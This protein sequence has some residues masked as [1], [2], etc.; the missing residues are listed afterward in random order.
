MLRGNGARPPVDII[1]VE[2]GPKGIAEIKKVI[3]ADTCVVFFH[4]RSTILLRALDQSCTIIVDSDAEYRRVESIIKQY[5]LTNAT[6]GIK[7]SANLIRIINAIPVATESFDNRGV[8][9]T[10]YLKTRMWEDLKRDTGPEID[11]VTAI[12]NG[13]GG[14]VYVHPI[15][16]GC[17]RRLAG[18]PNSLKA[19]S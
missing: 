6:S 15:R 13:N 12:L 16:Q 9:S 4:G 1:Y 14:G 18:T 7:Y 11:A 19:T 17:C 2:S 10:H 8:F 5:D 3:H